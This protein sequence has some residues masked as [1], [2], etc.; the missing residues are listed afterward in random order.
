M[1]EYITKYCKIF[2]ALQKE[3]DIMYGELVLILTK[4][5]IHKLA[6]PCE[7][8]L[9]GKSS[10]KRLLLMAI[11]TTIKKTLCL[12]WEVFLTTIDRCYVLKFQ[13]L[14]EFIKSYIKESW[15]ISGH[16]IRVMRWSPDF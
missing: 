16:Q 14:V 6:R 8:T 2:K 9:V 15:M 1:L 10:F 11:H 13:E 5:D 12:K 7:H 4:K 3:M